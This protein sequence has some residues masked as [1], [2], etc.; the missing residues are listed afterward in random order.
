MIQDI[1]PSHLDITYHPYEP[2]ED[3]RIL[4]FRQGE[5]LVLPSPKNDG[6]IDFPKYD[7][8]KRFESGYTYLFSID[9][10]RFFRVALTE[11]EMQTV[12]KA[13]KNAV[14]CRRSYFRTARP[15][16]L[17]FAA[18]TGLHLNGWYE[19]NRY[20]GSCQTKL[21]ADERERMLRCPCCGNMVYPRI[22]PAVIVAVTDQDR[23]LLTK[24]RGREYKNYALVAGFNEIGETLEETAIREVWE[25]TGLHI[26]NLRYYR[27]QP[28]GFADNLLVGFFCDVDGDP[29]IRMDEEELAVAEWVKRE[30]IPVKMEDMS[31]TNEMICRFKLDNQ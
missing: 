1:A 3:S 24:Y 12:V 9:R 29:S 6:E 16:A 14:F 28:W 26:R 25:E 15:K 18:V 2:D 8:A 22:D 7:G 13:E 30:E 27:S 17:A 4:F 31:L 21:E 11:E 23:L 19:K 10:Q 20:C 5:L